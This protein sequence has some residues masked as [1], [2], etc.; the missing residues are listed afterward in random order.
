MSLRSSGLRHIRYGLLLAL[1]DIP[2]HRH[3]LPF[4]HALD[5]LAPRARREPLAERNIDH[6]LIDLL[7]DLGGNLLLVGGGRGTRIGI[8][9]LFD[10]R[11]VR[12][13]ERA[14]LSA[15]ADEGAADRIAGICYHR[16][17]E[18]H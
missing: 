17:G 5:R 4:E 18:E 13:S 15:R 10:L 7:L 16:I 6:L 8:A 12:P 11:I 9:Q 2:E 1:L 3:R 14:L